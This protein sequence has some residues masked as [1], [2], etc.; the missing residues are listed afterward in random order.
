MN[1]EHCIAA[2]VQT[3]GD[4]W[5][6]TYCLTCKK[7]I[8]QDCCEPQG[9][10]WMTNHA[11]KSA[12]KTAHK[13][14]FG[15]F[16]KRKKESFPEITVTPPPL[17]PTVNPFEQFWDEC[18]SNKKLIETMNDAE[19]RCKIFEED[20]EEYV[21]DPRDGLHTI[22]NLCV[23]LKR[24]YE[25]YKKTINDLEEKIYNQEIEFGKEMRDANQKITDLLYTVSY[26]EKQLSLKKH[27]T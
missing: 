16:R 24:D 1:M 14:A 12:C 13:E 10:R 19:E 23:S 7:G 25:K 26:Q 22:I 15:A 3:K 8:M 11:K 9:S 20:N 17:P 6:F 18:K 27:A 5:G 21:F 4:E 2:S